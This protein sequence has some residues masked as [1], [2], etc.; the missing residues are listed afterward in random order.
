MVGGRTRLEQIDDDRATSNYLAKSL[1]V[2]P[3]TLELVESA[4]SSQAK[5]GL[6][7]RTPEIIRGRQAFR[8]AISRDESGEEGLVN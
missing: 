8:S 5:S 7:N 4:Q 2:R 3:V 6:T 1:D